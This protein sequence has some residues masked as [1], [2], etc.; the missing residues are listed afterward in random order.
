MSNKFAYIFDAIKWDYM[1]AE[2]ILGN[3][4]SIIAIP[5]SRHKEWSFCMR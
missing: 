5:V 3:G 1:I 4:S 2:A